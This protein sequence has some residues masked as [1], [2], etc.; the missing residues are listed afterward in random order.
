MAEADGQES[1]AWLRLGSWEIWDRYALLF[2][3][4]ITSLLTLFLEAMRW[5][6]LSLSWIPVQ[7]ISFLAAVLFVLIT[8]RVLR[9][10]KWLNGVRS[11]ANLV[12]AGT[13][14]GIKYWLSLFLANFFGMI[15]NQLYIPAFVIGFFLGVAVF[16]VYAQIRGARSDNP[17]GAPRNANLG[18]SLRPILSGMVTFL[19]WYCIAHQTLAQAT[20]TD[21]FFATIIYVAALYFFKLVSGLLK[22]I[23]LNL[24][25]I[26]IPIFCTL[27][28][29]P[30]YYLL[31]QIPHE[32]YEKPLLPSF[33][34]SA[35]LLTIGLAYSNLLDQANQ[36]KQN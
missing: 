11:E 25:V 8:V 16:I 24:A 14:M 4:L 15:D 3:F 2:G 9:A 20:S 18:S 19:A 10:I 29:L 28:T 21:L 17:T 26:L 5:E 12:I 6:N 34:V 33:I 35:V 32:I 22:N 27:A 30:S 13:G 31:Y 23:S 7:I 36:E 1:K